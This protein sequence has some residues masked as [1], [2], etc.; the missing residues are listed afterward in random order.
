MRLNTLL[1][2][3]P[4][5]SVP[6][7]RRG[8]VLKH[9]YRVLAIL[10]Y[11]P[12]R[13]RIRTLQALDELTRHAEVDLVCLNDGGSLD[14]PAG[15]RKRLVVP[16]ASQMERA[17][18]ILL[19]LLGGRPITQ[20]F[21]NS[22][23]L[24]RV[25]AGINLT[26]YDA[27][28]V[29]RLPVYRYLKHPRIIYDCVD[30]CSHLNR[31]MA[32]RGRGYKR[33]LYGLDA[34]LLPRHERAACDGASVV[35]VAANREV[36][37]LRELGVTSPIEVWIQ[38]HEVG[39]APRLLCQRERF[40]VSFHGKLSYAANELALRILNDVIAPALDDSCYDLRIIGKHPAGF[41]R[42]FP[43]LQFTGF[44]PSIMDSLRDS[45]LSIFPLPVSVG[46]PNKAMESLAAGVP[47]VATPDV[48][49]G[50][51]SS[52]EILEQGIYV[53]NIAE[54]PAE[55]E[56]YRRLDLRERQRISQRCYEYAQQISSSPSR[57][58]QWERILGGARVVSDPAVGVGV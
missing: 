14:V 5:Q 50:F 3:C 17:F 11:S 15:V 23:R 10:P 47:F 9:G 48:V 45:D 8:G 52:P 31:L 42:K 49:D 22:M 21:Y 29:E 43:Q 46:F 26:E 38:E 34:L 58:A 33:L 56:R 54:F 19:G 40:V 1:E 39:V 12:N 16:N 53:R 13:V 25:L 27:L 18:R 24:R 37:E 6:D 4:V 55:V 2:G 51:P 36:R 44:V 35:L 32:A 30:C 20:E 7:Q 41:R 28:Y 57:Q